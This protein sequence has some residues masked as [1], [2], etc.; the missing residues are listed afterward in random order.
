MI[1]SSSVLVG[2]RRVSG[3]RVG[4]ARHLA[5]LNTVVLGSPNLEDDQDDRLHYICRSLYIDFKSSIQ[6]LKE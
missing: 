5:G 2:D 3:H 4:A 6:I 1:V